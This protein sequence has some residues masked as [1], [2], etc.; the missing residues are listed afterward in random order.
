M[1]DDSKIELELI[2]DLIKKVKIKR[3]SLDLGS[4]FVYENI[5]CDFDIFACFCCFE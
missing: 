1:K 4:R 5:F 3:R 2:D